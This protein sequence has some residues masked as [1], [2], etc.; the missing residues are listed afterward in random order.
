M[1]NDRR[2]DI[3]VDIPARFRSSAT[4]AEADEGERRPHLQCKRIDATSAG[5]VEG[6]ST[7]L[8]EGAVLERARIAAI[9]TCRE[10]TSR[11]ELANQLAFRS[12]VSAEAAREMLA[13]SPEQPV[14]NALAIIMSQVKNPDVGIGGYASS[15]TDD[16]QA[17][18]MAGSVMAEYR[19]Q[20]PK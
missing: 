15:M 17:A 7:G 10:A 12:N 18:A 16:Q 13:T 20:N 4:T 3:D 19:K 6:L 14:P 5:R 2:F 8:Q 11:I 9:L 1:N